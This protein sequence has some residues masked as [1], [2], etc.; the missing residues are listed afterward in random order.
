[1]CLWCLQST[2]FETYILYFEFDMYNLQ[3]VHYICMH[4]LHKSSFIMHI[5]I[6]IRKIHMHVFPPSQVQKKK[7]ETSHVFSQFFQQTCNVQ[8]APLTVLP[9]G[10]RWWKWSE[11]M[12]CEEPLAT[13]KD[14]GFVFSEHWSKP[15]LSRVY[16]GIILPSYMDVSENRGKT[17][18]MDGEH[19]GNPY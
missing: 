5:Y 9:Q 6:Y 10:V 1:M 14:L 2:F 19:N 3:S 7:Y 16:M 17:P 18:E 4:N 11:P 12:W 8:W 15:W 13:W